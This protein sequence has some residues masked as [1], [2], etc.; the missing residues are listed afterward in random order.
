MDKKYELTNIA[1]EMILTAYNE[2]IKNLY[3]ELK[4]D[5][6]RNQFK[7]IIK[8]ELELQV[9]K[10]GYVLDLNS[11]SY[12]LIT[13][14]D[15]TSSKV[16]FTGFGSVPEYTFIK[17]MKQPIIERFA[18]YAMN[19]ILNNLKSNVPLIKYSSTELLYRGLFGINLIESMLLTYM[20][21]KE[22]PF[23]DLQTRLS[24][25]LL[26]NM[27]WNKL[28]N[29]YPLKC[30]AVDYL[31]N[32]IEHDLYLR[33]ELWITRDGCIEFNKH[34]ELAESDCY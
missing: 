4:D 18:P 10:F 5:V 29:V 22:L 25:T 11:M 32:V 20:R 16:S 7:S 9:I 31:N 17:N 19:V 27:W 8:K 34:I 28:V 13:D 33:F 3:F 23:S 12:K 6:T 1:E 2:L 14:C 15:I 24:I 21:Y 26:F 30:V